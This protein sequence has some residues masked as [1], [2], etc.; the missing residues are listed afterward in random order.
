[1]Y[2]LHIGDRYTLSLLLPRIFP[3][4]GNRRQKSVQECLDALK[5][6]EIWYSTGGRQKMAKQG[7]LARKEKLVTST[8]TKKNKKQKDMMSPTIETDSL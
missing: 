7:V 2:I 6:W 5:A 1:M 4:L 3:Y 8:S